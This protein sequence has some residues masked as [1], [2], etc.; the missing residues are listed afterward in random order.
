LASGL[1]SRT[2]ALALDLRHALPAL[3]KGLLAASI[4]PAAGLPVALAR[5]L[6]GGTIALALD[7]R[8]ALIAMAF[9]LLAALLDLLRALLLA[10]RIGLLNPLAADLHGIALLV[11]RARRGDGGQGG[12]SRG[13]GS[14][15]AA[16]QKLTY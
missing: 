1:P 10:C 8:G 15:R 14:D 5:R 6:P 16:P 9:D 2:V 4:G 7:L 3:A 13:E 11:D 12:D